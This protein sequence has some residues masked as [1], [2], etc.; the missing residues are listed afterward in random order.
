MTHRYAGEQL[1]KLRQKGQILDLCFDL[2]PETQRISMMQEIN[3][4]KISCV[5]VKS[6]Y[7]YL[8]AYNIA[9][10][11]YKRSNDINDTLSIFRFSVFFT[12]LQCLYNSKLQDN[13]FDEELVK[14]IEKIKKQKHYTEALTEIISSL[15]GYDRQIFHLIG[16]LFIDM[17]AIDSALKLYEIDQSAFSN[18]N[19][20][21]LLASNT[22]KNNNLEWAVKLT[23][24]LIKQ[25][26]Y[27]PTIPALQSDI[28]HLEQRNHLTSIL[29]IDFSEIDQ[30][31]GVE[32]ENLL[33]DKF[34]TMGFKVEST[35]TTG[36]YGADLIVENSEGSRI[37]VQCKRFKSK[38]NLKAVQE[39]VGAMGHYAGDYG[40]VITNNSFLNSAIK[41]AESHD[42]ELWDGD[43]LVSFLAEDLSFSEIIGS[44]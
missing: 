40:V 42:I 17:G 32:F 27:H 38:V 33:E 36:D 2:L 43:K 19:I 31:S 23:D 34:T 1:A 11:R 39:V 22:I 41:L 6:K 9:E 37:I 24:Q 18:P 35:P 12:P 44:A 7:D 10:E 4:Q 26:P 21:S 29:L 28:K 16:E 5:Y 30:L 25:E 15:L 8:V 20:L 13:I 3:N 14:S